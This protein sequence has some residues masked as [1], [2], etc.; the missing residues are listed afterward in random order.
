MVSEISLNSWLRR[1]WLGLTAVLAVIS[2][3]VQGFIL[4]GLTRRTEQNIRE[5]V[6]IV[7]EDIESTLDGVDSFIYESLYG[8]GRAAVPPRFRILGSETDPAELSSTRIEVMLSLQSLISW[9][10]MIE[11]IFVCTPRD[12]EVFTLE[13]GKDGSYPARRELKTYFTGKILAGELREL[14][15]YM[16][17][18]GDSGTH[19][20]RI[21][22][23]DSSY[24][25]VCVSSEKLLRT[26]QYAN[27]N[28]TGM[29]FVSSD[30]RI[31]ADTG[32]RLPS[33][34]DES[35]EG[36]YIRAGGEIC[37]QTG[38]VSERSGWYF[39]ILTPRRTI[40][41]NLAGYYA[42]SLLLVLA[43][44][45]ALPLLF[46]R[47]NRKV[48]KPIN[49]IAGSMEEV[50]GGD[51]DISIATDSRI[52]ELGT[53]TRSFNHMVSEIKQLKIEKYESELRVQKATMQY[54][55]L[56][57]KP[58]FYANM[59]NIIYSLAQRQDYEAI[60]KVSA[61]VVSYS[62]YMFR[63]ASEM[64]E[65][66]RELEHVRGYIEI[67]R[68]RYGSDIRCEIHS[69]E[70]LRGALVPPFV[71]EGF[72]ENSVKYASVPG[73]PFL[74]TVNVKLQDNGETLILE[75]RDNGTGYSEKVLASD[76][77]NHEIDGGHIGLTN[78]Y[79]R[80]KIVYG[81][82][83][84]MEIR[85]E[86]GAVTTVRIPYISDDLDMDDDDI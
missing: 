68:I 15:R 62:R 13:A 80:L 71:I 73:R 19:L 86:N 76:W 64:V 29:A 40:M 37:L 39:G 22:R 16:V 5:N 78:I 1:Y 66:W 12:G 27:L 45:A 8:G 34:L 32:A 72:V 14:D 47:L 21:M 41:G 84:D 31:I 81:D 82:R 69:S 33:P 2:L 54:L 30:G 83:A 24:I 46:K 50:A 28:G 63:D 36:E 61:A 10:D 49:A 23:I 59:F 74:V 65:L 25:V 35:T 55:Q 18:E 42:A 56:Q 77:R 60:Q 58:H 38:Y 75:I 51:L 6:H 9:S 26:L 70:E 79:N 7:Q 53:L 11:S 43:L 85:N 44:M 48:G 57:I 17:F 3:T 4:T 52:L 20:L 67:S